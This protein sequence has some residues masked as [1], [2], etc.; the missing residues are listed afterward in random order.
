MANYATT[1][2][3]NGGNSF[4]LDNQSGVTDPHIFDINEGVTITV[5]G[6]LTGSTRLQKRGLGTLLIQGN[7]SYTGGVQIS[8]GILEITA[9]RAL[10]A[11]PSPGTTDHMIFDGGNLKVTFGGNFAFRPNR[12]ITINDSTGTTGSGIIANITDGNSDTAGELH[13]TN[14]ITG[15]GHIEF[16]GPEGQHTSSIRFTETSTGYTGSIIV[17]DNVALVLDYSDPRLNTAVNFGSGTHN[18]ILDG[19]Q[20]RGQGRIEGNVVT[21]GTVLP[22][23]DVGGALAINGN[24]TADSLS[25]MYFGIARQTGAPATDPVL[26]DELLVTG[27]VTLGGKIYVLP[28]Y[29]AT[30]FTQLPTGGPGL[31]LVNVTGS[32][33]N[34]LNLTGDISDLD[35]DVIVLRDANYTNTS[36]DITGVAFELG[37]AT[38]NRLDLVKN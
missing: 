12:G 37:G 22:G 19:G 4:N 36:F 10:G 18:I 24:F 16:F 5:T 6:N 38:N 30:N 20:L 17:H 34:N 13:I 32:L 2:P 9:D 3:L 1:A 23:R 21:A 31:E 35:S 29:D 14:P 11:Q 15:S 28:Y 27:N 33:T 25:V 7:K 8:S 26:H